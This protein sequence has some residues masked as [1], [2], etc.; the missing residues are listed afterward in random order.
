MHSCMCC[1]SWRVFLTV[2][3]FCRALASAELSGLV[4]E[5]NYPPMCSYLPLVQLDISLDFWFYK[6]YSPTPWIFSFSGFSPVSILENLLRALL[7][8]WWSFWLFRVL[9]FSEGDLKWSGELEGAFYATWYWWS[10]L[11]LLVVYLL[12]PGFLVHSSAIGWHCSCGIILV[13]W[14]PYDKGAPKFSEGLIRDFEWFTWGS[15][16]YL[17]VNSSNDK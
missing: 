2:W 9:T 17:L 3:I 5:A 6:V 12:S 8:S 16:T 15:L 13:P 7:C 11:I 14:F 10:I 4:G 1:H